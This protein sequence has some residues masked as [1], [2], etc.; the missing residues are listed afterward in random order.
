[1]RAGESCP[2]VFKSTLIL[3]I[4]VPTVLDCVPHPFFSHPGYAPPN[5]NHFFCKEDKELIKIRA[6]FSKLLNY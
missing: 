6:G 1:M 3:I 5:S 2:N 4:C